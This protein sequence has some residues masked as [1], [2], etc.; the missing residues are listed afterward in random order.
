M[1]KKAYDA[2][3]L[4]MIGFA[5]KLAKKERGDTNFISILIVLGIVII[6]AGVFLVFKNKIVEMVKG[7]I[8]GFDINNSSTTLPG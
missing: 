5:N 8:E 1:L 4:K 2:L 6:V 7:V 3:E